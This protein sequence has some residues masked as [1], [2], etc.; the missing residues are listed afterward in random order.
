M[1]VCAVLV[2]AIVLG[3]GCGASA[4]EAPKRGEVVL[5]AKFAG[6]A[7]LQGW[8]GSGAVDAGYQG[9]KALRVEVAP[10]S[11]PLG[12]SSRWTV[13]IERLRGCTIRL[14]GMVR[15]ENVS[16]RPQ[17]WNGIKM[18]MPIT[19]PGGVQYPQAKVE[20]GTFDWK[21]IGCM[22]R[23]P[24]DATA[25][26]LLLGLEEVSG[27]V[28]FSDVR[29]VVLQPPIS[30]KVRRASGPAYRGHNLPRLRGTM[31]SPGITKESLRTLGGEW[32][33]NLIR[34]QLVRSN[35]EAA[36][37]PDYDKWLNGELAKL[38]AAL[39]TC[40]Q[41]GVLVVVDL[42][43]PP[44]GAP[45]AGG[46]AA[47]DADLFS[48]K[49]AQAK[50]VE[51]WQRIARRYKGAGEIWGFDLVNEPIEDSLAE[52]TDDWHGLAE[53][54]AKAVRE[55]DPKRTL[56]VECAAGGNPGGFDS[57]EPIDVPNVVYS[58]HMYLPH[59]FTHQGVFGPSAPIRYPGTIDG[60]QWDRAQLE[61]ALKPVVDFQR[62]YNV[63]IYVG[64]FSAIRWAPDDSAYRY[65]KDL[66]DI[67][68]EHGWDWTYH[69][70][71]EWDGW[72]VE[73]GRDRADTQ[74]TKTPTTR[75]TLLR[76][77][78]AKNRRAG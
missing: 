19:S 50:F 68:E 20:T 6:E 54:A 74:P 56:I 52:D 42:H 70:F 59:T 72:S 27:R 48:S 8:A 10:G 71:R 13:P 67:F 46:Y 69:A 37:Q 63:H 11:K 29:I 36:A 3:L 21:R 38:D 53:R 39:P 64:E 41:L 77:W 51:A 15:A 2:G 35:Q 18:M 30:D 66:I 43:S 73:H 28:W 55:I 45:S 31:I 40:R 26:H 62:K 47:A 76:E 1:N 12:G 49:D 24:K 78:F 14:S 44:G 16:D 60:K 57:L 32:H 65:L 7:A 75:Q 34:W 5:S 33:A 58:V 22:I 17:S 61:A 25:A 9:G 4:Q 23:V